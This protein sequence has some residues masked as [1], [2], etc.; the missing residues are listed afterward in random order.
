MKKLLV[1]GGSGSS[2]LLVG[3]SLDQ[4]T[5]YIDPRRTIIITDKTVS[6]LNQ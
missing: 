6:W 1:R 5:D 4:L 2:Q 3:E